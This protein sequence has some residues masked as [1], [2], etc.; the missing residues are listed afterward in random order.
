[1]SYASSH[2][3]ICA[4]REPW[5][6][7]CLLACLRVPNAATGPGGPAASAH[8]F[9]PTPRRYACSEEER[10]ER[11]TTNDALSYLREV[12]TRFANNRKVYDRC[13]CCLGCGRV[14]VQAGGGCMLLIALVGAAGSETPLRP[15]GSGAAPA[16]GCRAHQALP[17][18]AAQLPGDHEAV[19]GA[20]VRLA[21]ARAAGPGFL[22]TGAGA[23]P[24][25]TLGFAA[26][27]SR[28]PARCRF[29]V[30]RRPAR[31]ALALPP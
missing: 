22:G 6:S 24:R 17:P 11:L 12:K 7:C 28:G 5:S 1:M 23:M 9:H 13:G 19:Q 25:C 29:A 15:A 31:A 27:W 16:A 30:P 26:F 14:W 18:P 8:R 2:A 3:A 4:R 20:E 10:R 21:G